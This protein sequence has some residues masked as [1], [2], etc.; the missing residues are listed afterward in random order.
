ML[1]GIAG[2]VDGDWNNIDSSVLKNAKNMGFKTLQIRVSDTETITQ[3]NIHRIRSLYKD[4]GFKMPQTVGDYGGGLISKNEEIR[5]KAIKFVKKMINFTSKIEGENTYLRPGS[6]N[7]EPWNPHPENYT[8]ETFDR[9][10]DSTKQ[11]IKVAENEGV[12]VAVEGGVSCPVSTP[13]KVKDLF[14][15][16]GSKY[17]GFNMDPV[18]F[19]GSLEIAY[20]NTKL[21]EDFYSLI[22]D[23]IFGCHAKDFTIVENLLPHFKE[24]II[25][26]PNSLLDNESLLRGLMKVNPKAHV[27][28][29]HLPNDKIPEALEGI[30]RVANRININWD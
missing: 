8:A 27:L 10:I 17:L 21:I 18:N 22:P 24:S 7:S 20:N 4:F 29:E 28:I 9:L 26:A 25:D 12:F 14:D 1:L 13:K 5:K 19:I 16:V 3:K 15:G 11:I 23:K 6:I 30:N 2:L